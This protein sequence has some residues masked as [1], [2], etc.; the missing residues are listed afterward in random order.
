MVVA[1]LLRRGKGL[2]PGQLRALFPAD[3]QLVQPGDAV[4]IQT[5]RLLPGPDLALRFQP[6]AQRQAV[7][8]QIV[9]GQL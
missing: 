3:V 5:A 2:F 8:G 6:A 1:V 4:C 7:L 9:I